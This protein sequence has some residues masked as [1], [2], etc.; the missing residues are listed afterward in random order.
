VGLAG[1]GAA[2]PTL[3]VESAGGVAESAGGAADLAVESADAEAW[4][5]DD[6]AGGGP[7]GSARLR[8]IF[9]SGRVSAAGLSLS[10]DEVKAAF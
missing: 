10:E 4:P 5:A 8:C 2:A 6:A 7:S 9:G 3:A 1:L